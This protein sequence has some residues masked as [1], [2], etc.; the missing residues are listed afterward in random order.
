MRR[1]IYLTESSSKTGTTFASLRPSAPSRQ[2]AGVGFSKCGYEYEKPDTT[3]VKPSPVDLTGSGAPL[4]GAA[5]LPTSA[6]VP[7]DPI[8]RTRTSPVV[9][10]PLTAQERLDG[11]HH[12]QLGR[13]RR[14]CLP[15][16]EDDEA[17]GVLFDGD[18]FT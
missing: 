16:T 4:V 10:A 3:Q 2:A 8:V 13:T 14:I 6:T 17:G 5:G 11:W 18:P 12:S 9:E 1:L 7:V 15:V